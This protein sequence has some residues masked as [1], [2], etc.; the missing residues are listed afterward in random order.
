MSF[1]YPDALK[2]V[3]QDKRGTHQCVALI[4]AHTRAGHTSTWR[5]G[6]KV[7][8]NLTLPVGTAIATFEDGRYRS[9]PHGNHA[10][11]YVGQ[12]AT[13]LVVVD[14]WAGDKAPDKISKRPLRFC[15]AAACK[16]GTEA[17]NDG[18]NYWVIE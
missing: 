15:S 14:Q 16:P 12:D 1:V 2:L 5:Q 6:A 17:V 13:C 8:G 18:D 7:R 4:Q 11:F 3:G 9:R 10:A